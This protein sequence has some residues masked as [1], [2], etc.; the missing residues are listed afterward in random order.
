[1]E[2][3]KDNQQSPINKPKAEGKK[4]VDKKAR[5]WMGTCNN[6]EVPAEAY[7]KAIFD[8][9]KLTYVCGQ[10]EQ[11]EEGTKHV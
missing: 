9:G 6:P 8:T 3:D 4:P 11:G 7:L 10:L 1:M 2:M 5:S